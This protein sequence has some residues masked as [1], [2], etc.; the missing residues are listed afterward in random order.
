MENFTMQTLGLS[1]EILKATDELGFI[2][3]TPIQQE[4]IPLLINKKT[5]IVALAQTGTGKTAAY[6]LPLLDKII[7]QE[8]NTQA[9]ILSPTRELCIQIA[10][11]LKVYAR[12]KS[13]IK[14]EAVYGG[15]DISRQIKA[16]NRGV[17]VI[18][19]TPGRMLDLMMRGNA[20]ISSISTIVLDEAD[21]MLNMGF[22]EDLNA[23]LK[24]TPSSKNTHLFS[25]TMPPAAEKIAATYMNKPEKIIIGKKN[26]GAENV[27]HLYYRVQAKHRYEALKRIA[28]VN[29]DIY[30]IVFCRTR[31]ETKEFASK[32]IHD[33]YNADALHG[34]LTQAQ[35]DSVMEKFRIK[36]LR[37]LVATDVAARGLDVTDLTHVINVDL[38][39][40]NEIYTHRSGRTGRAG[41]AGIS[42]SIIHSRETGKLRLIENKIGKKFEYKEVPAGKEICAKQLFHMIDKMQNVH[43]NEQQINDYLPDVFQKLENLSKEDLIKNFV[44]LE[45]NRF[46]EY[47]KNAEDINY[48][49]N[50]KREE[51]G[52]RGYEGRLRKNKFRQ[53]RSEFVRF[54]I[55]LGSKDN[56]NAKS[57]IGFIN[58]Q[59]K[60]RDMQIGKV[61]I[62]KSFS[63]FEVD[64]YYSQAVLGS[65]KNATFDG[66]KTV[67]EMAQNAARN[68]GIGKHRHPF[69]KTGFKRK[70]HRGSN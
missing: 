66:R 38:P 43:V 24:G 12:Y 70:V 2:T 39:D 62:L 32:L 17:H 41:K 11:D 36:N 40:D 23:I 56:M 21:E 68:K 61:E 47:Y 42:I 48:T 20:D 13:G 25:A 8:F 60:N 46:L 10:K 50:R 64:E 34:D 33:G 3:P 53:E 30:A 45:F 52:E 54:Y 28:D 18:V 15:T 6:G 63:F 55:N 27:I 51:R 67:V 69:S 35:R 49:D 7:Q 9:L 37:M 31:A 16:L 5:D 44:S 29:P 22:Q 26:S 19:A 58:R 59:C 65:F 14:I 1:P 57:L 4:V